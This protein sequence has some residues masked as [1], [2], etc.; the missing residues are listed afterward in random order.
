[1]SGQ[2]RVKLVLLWHMHQPDFRDHTSG[3]FMQPWVYLHALKD[4]SDMAAHL[5]A[6]PAMRVVV[7]LV[8]IL[9]DQLEDYAD[10]FASGRLRDPLLRLLAHPD[11]DSIDTAQREVLL[12][13]CFRAN[14]VKMIEP[15]APFKRLRDLYRYT[16]DH[17]H[18][19]LAYLSGQY[20][21]DLVTWYHLAWTGETVRHDEELV[22]QLMTQGQ[23]FTPAQRRALFELIGRVVADTIP[24]YRRLAQSGQ[25]E[26]SSTPYFHPIGPLLLEF[27][28]AREAMPEQA[29]PH[30]GNYPGGRTRVNWHIERAL[31]SH[32]QRFGVPAR[33]MWPAEGAV[34]LP[35]C[36]AL[37]E[38]GVQWAATGEAVLM[39]SLRKSGM[40]VNERGE[41]LY[42]PYRIGDAHGVVCFF[43]DDRLSDAIGFEYKGWHGSEAAAHFI[44]TLEHIEAAT[45]AGET[46]VVSVML[47]GENAWEFYPYNGYYFLD[48]LYRRLGAHATLTTATCSDV[49]A[50]ARCM[51]RARVLPE[52]VTGSWVF[53]N[54]A[55]WIGSHDKNRAWELLLSAKQ[56]YDLVIASGRLTPEEAKE[57]EL[58][59]AVCEGSDWTW[60]FGDY[61]P[62]ESVQ[63][64]DRLYRTYLANLYRLLKL[65]P[66]PQLNEPISLGAVNAHTD[67]AMRRAA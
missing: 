11:L 47:D 31:A 17:G 28:S 54:L 52:M 53:G 29:F 15:F 25:I 14:H 19:A 61:N 67:G 3:E 20:L 13:Q 10:Q 41:A 64:F 60:W 59:L 1:M 66:P 39:N 21:A 56:C 24:R 32:A 33:G 40:A 8:P 35:F 62:A 45:P 42:R 50:D 51:T 4:Y 2:G 58:Q 7:N 36:Q 9:L 30:L 65:D 18:E 26:L 16:I 5:E 23:N 38:H 22:V 49:L 44:T 55:T 27:D 43:R 63:S 6:H 37:R 34:S 46:A 48:E 12:N 57:A